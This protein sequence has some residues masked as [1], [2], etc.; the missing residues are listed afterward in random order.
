VF[1]R[2]QEW[3]QPR[4]LEE[5]V[6]LLDRPEFRSRLLAGGTASGGGVDAD[7]EALIDLSELGL[8]YIRSRHASIMLGALTTLADLL[9]SPLLTVAAGGVLVQTAGRAGPP[10]LLAR[11]TVGGALAM[12][13]RAPELIATLLALEARVVTVH[14]NSAGTG[15]L[16]QGWELGEFLGRRTELLVG[17]IIE[18]VEFPTAPVTAAWERVARTP[19]DLP[20]VSVVAAAQMQGGICQ[21]VRLAATGLTRWPERL[22][23]AELDLR[24]APLTPEFI[25]RAAM[26]ARQSVFP[27]ADLR[28]T[29]EY[30]RHLAEVLVR[31]ALTTLQEARP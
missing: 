13:E 21:S 27:A 24:G 29:T 5:A 22:A 7:T 10:T 11:A 9:A 3:E 15:I 20:I 8:R 14:S 1:L 26:V 19:R 30:R 12:P 16:R 2:L 25:V 23:A 17:A 4:T 28:G 18:E 6:Q 31:R